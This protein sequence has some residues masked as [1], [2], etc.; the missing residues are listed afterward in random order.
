M[1]LVCFPEHLLNFPGYWV[2]PR[3]DESWQERVD[4]VAKQRNYVIGRVIRAFQMN[5]KG[6]TVW[7][8][9]NG[10]LLNLCQPSECYAGNATWIFVGN[11]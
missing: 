2:S 5:L 4:L 7:V 3:S 6:L 11:F 1:G 9:S 10:L 8:H